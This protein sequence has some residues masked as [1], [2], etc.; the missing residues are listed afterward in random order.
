MDLK[1]QN[2]LFL[3]RTM[4]IGGTENVVLQ[5]CEILQSQVNKIVVCSCGG[6]NVEKLENAGIKHYVISDITEKKPLLMIYIYKKIRKIIEYENIT[7]IHSH[8]RMASLYAS[9][10]FNKNIIKIATAHNTFN[11]KVRLTKLAYNKTHIVAV[12][13]T[14]EKNLVNFF[15]IPKQR[16]TVIHNAVKPFNKEI[17][18]VSELIKAKEQGYLLIGNVGRLSKQKGMEYFIEAAKKVSKEYSKV[19]FYIIG[20]GEDAE[21][22]HIL[23]NDMLQKGILVF[24]GYRSD[25][26]NIISQ[27]DFIVLSSLWEGLPLTPIEAF[28]VGKLVIGTAVDGTVEII[29]DGVDG[30]L[31]DSRNSNIIADKIVYLISHPEEIVRMGKNAEKRY[32][33]EFSYEKLEQS[34]IDYYKNLLLD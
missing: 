21:K 30:F 7:I 12:G 19:K 14:V 16:V 28:S 32:Y 10:L 8:H 31:V 13:Q 25:I 15:G 26:Q 1:E 6:I 4:G 17:N 5:L 29:R 3:T 34:Y 18:W 20:D 23:A 11:S 33:E 22:L 9:L 27:M 24:L 2:I